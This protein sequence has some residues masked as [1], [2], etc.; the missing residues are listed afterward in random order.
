MLDDVAV[1]RHRLSSH[2]LTSRERR[3]SCHRP[4]HA[5]QDRLCDIASLAPPGRAIDRHLAVALAQFPLSEDRLC[6]TA[7]CRVEHQQAPRACR[8]PACRPRFAPA[9]AI[10][11]LAVPLAHFT[12]SEDRLGA[13]GAIDRHLSVSLAHLTRPRTGLGASLRAFRSINSPR[14][15]AID[16]HS[17]LRWRT[18]GGTRGI[19]IAS[20]RGWSAHCSRA[21]GSSQQTACC[22]AGAPQERGV[23][24]APRRGWSAHFSRAAGS[25]QPTST[26]VSS[27]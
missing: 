8:G 22:C 27:R 23:D 25:S 2:H 20:R 10:D 6:A 21:G 19:E 24:I 16:R 12:L 3:R 1:G 7:C 4:P 5:T 17:L 15:W 26:F 11:S 9:R 14:N 13:G 18:S